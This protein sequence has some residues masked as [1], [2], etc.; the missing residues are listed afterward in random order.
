MYLCLTVLQLAPYIASLETSETVSF[1]FTQGTIED[2]CAKGW[3]EYAPGPNL[4][5]YEEDLVPSSRHPPARRNSVNAIV[6]SYETDQGG[7]FRAQRS[8]HDALHNVHRYMD[9]NGPFDGVVG[10]SAG[11]SL[12]ATVLAEDQEKL[13]KG[14]PNRNLKCG[15]FF[16]AYPPFTT[17]GKKL[18]LSDE[19]GELIG[20]PTL[21]VVSSSDTFHAS[22]LA[23]WK[24]CSKGNSFLHEHNQGHMIPWQPKIVRPLATLIRDFLENL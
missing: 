16:C 23:L 4:R 5:F 1:H 2:T 21:H 10:F 12:A 19:Y 9:E 3:N 22:S 6:R 20:V 13:R 8:V 24:L 17:D 18:M 11:G 15:I 7:N 14:L